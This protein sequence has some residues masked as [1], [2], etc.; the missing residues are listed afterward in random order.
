MTTQPNDSASSYAGQSSAAPPNPSTS[1]DPPGD[2]GAR[3]RIDVRRSAS[4]VVEVRVSGELDMVGAPLLRGKLTE[5]MANCRALVL[6]L[7][8]VEFLG[9]A[10]LSILLEASK[11]AEHQNVRWGIVASRHAVT[12]PLRAVG[13]RDVL[14]VHTSVAIATSAVTNTSITNRSIA[15]N[16]E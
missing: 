12:H 6:D 16:V 10:G 7:G 11:L 1:G 2:S 8:G 9:T 13:L 15:D 4:E 5:E 3:L 14:P